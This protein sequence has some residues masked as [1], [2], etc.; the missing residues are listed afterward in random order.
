MAP[1]PAVPPETSPRWAWPP[2]PHPQKA[3]PGVLCLPP[4]HRCLGAYLQIH[5]WGDREGGWRGRP[6]FP[7]PLGSGQGAPVGGQELLVLRGASAGRAGQLRVWAAGRG[8]QASGW[9]PG[10]PGLGAILLVCAG[11]EWMGEAVWPQKGCQ[12]SGGEGAGGGCQGSLTPTTTRPAC[13]APTGRSPPGRGRGDQTKPQGVLVGPAQET[14]ET[15]V[16]ALSKAPYRG[17]SV[18]F[19]LGALGSP[20]QVVLALPAAPA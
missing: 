3:G 11:A 5:S 1:P 18:P 2:E 20:Q 9:G 7:G 17:Q 14:A 10:G 13:P 16:T 8:L 4:P 6:S 15:L 12:T 19:P